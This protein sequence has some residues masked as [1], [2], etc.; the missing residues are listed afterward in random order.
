MTPVMKPIVYHDINGVLF[1]EYGPRKPL[2][3]LRPETS[4]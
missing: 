2:Q 4:E 1:G 3:I